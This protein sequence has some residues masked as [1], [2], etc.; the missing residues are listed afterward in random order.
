MKSSSRGSWDWECLTVQS[1][2]LTMGSGQRLTP[3]AGRCLAAILLACLALTGR[4]AA[5][6]KPEI[7]LQELLQMFPGHYDNTAQVQS[8]LA[9]GVP[10]PHEAVTLD[11]VPIEAIM[12]GENV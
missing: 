10:S 7:A 12:L 2:G 1:G 3:P 4:A 11:I 8:E 6:E 9:Q 5:G